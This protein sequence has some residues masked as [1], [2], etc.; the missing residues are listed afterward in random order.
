[1]SHP[2]R[3]RQD[4]LPG[5]NETRPR[6][7]PVVNARVSRR[8]HNAI[9]HPRHVA[10]LHDDGGGSLGRDPVQPLIIRLAQRLPPDPPAAVPARLPSKHP[11]QRLEA[12]RRAPASVPVAPARAQPGLH[13]HH[14]AVLDRRRA[15]EREARQPRVLDVPRGEEDHGAAPEHDVEPAV[16]RDHGARPEEVPLLDRYPRGEDHG[17]DGHGGAAHEVDE[18]VDEEGRVVARPPRV[19][20]LQAH[21]AETTQE[22]WPRAATVCLRWRRADLDGGAQ[23]AEDYYAHHG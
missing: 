12:V 2:P 21:A 3:N 8:T 18:G 16:A 4:I 20:Q 13:P 9:A 6:R 23:Q 14:V 11:R 7:D 5:I 1:M 19:A 17:A 22:A 15:Q 10:L